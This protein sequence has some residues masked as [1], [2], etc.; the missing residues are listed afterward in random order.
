MRQLNDLGDVN[1]SGPSDAQLLTFQNISS[2]WVNQNKPT[3]SIQEQTDFDSSITKNNLDYMAW[4]S[5]TSKWEPI[6]VDTEVVNY[7][8]I[9]QTADAI[10]INTTVNAGFNKFNILNTALANHSVVN[11]GTAFTILNNYT[12]RVNDTGYYEFGISATSENA[13]MNFTLVRNNVLTA[14]APRGDNN[15]CTSFNLF[16]QLAAND[17]LCFCSD[18]VGATIRNVV[19]Y[20]KKVEYNKKI[21][22]SVVNLGTSLEL[23]SDTNI[24]GKQNND[25]LVYN[26]ATT[27]WENKPAGYT[28]SYWRTYSL[29]ATASG[30]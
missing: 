29:N 15:N 11:V 27:K 3:Y 16:T 30:V 9:I 19:A 12:L 23:L 28:P 20:I 21:V 5:S 8:R 13:N 7:L 1:I 18:V 2:Q 22:N 24:I 26:S 10:S 17:Q 6:T 14:Y 25:T 4:N